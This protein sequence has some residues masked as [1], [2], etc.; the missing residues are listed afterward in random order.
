MNLLQTLG[1]IFSQC[2]HYQDDLALCDVVLLDSQST[3]D[4]FCNKDMVTS[5][6]TSPSPCTFQSNGGTLTITQKAKVSGL[7][8][9]LWFDPKA[10]TNIL[11]L[12][13]LSS[14]YH[15]TYD[16]QDACFVVH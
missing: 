7:Q 13:T 5:I 1:S 9:D 10:L 12:H 2:A 6:Y 3:M 11:A 16:S 4:L 15:V 8:E 14:K